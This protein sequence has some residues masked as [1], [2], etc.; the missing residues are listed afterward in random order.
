MTT[1]AQIKREFTEADFPDV[2]FSNIDS[3]R[4]K[5]SSFG[6][7]GHG[8]ALQ[9]LQSK[10]LS[11]YP[12]HSKPPPEQKDDGTAEATLKRFLRIRSVPKED[13]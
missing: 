10:M 1:E 8:F 12:H 7:A 6:G 13:K 5:A 11:L 9:F 2:D 4:R 3:L